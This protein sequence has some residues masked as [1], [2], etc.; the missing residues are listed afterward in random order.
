MKLN[1]HPNRGDLHVTRFEGRTRITQYHK[2]EPRQIELSFPE[3]LAVLTEM[4]AVLRDINV[5]NSW[6][7]S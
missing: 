1:T 2:G 7:Y 4:A 5:D 6:R 3:A